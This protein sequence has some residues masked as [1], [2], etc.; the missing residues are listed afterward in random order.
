MTVVVPEGYPVGAS[1]KVQ[2]GHHKYFYVQ[3]PEG[4]APGNQLS[5][6]VPESS[7]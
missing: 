2:T 1:L 5:V 6:Q 3:I 4:V 7:P